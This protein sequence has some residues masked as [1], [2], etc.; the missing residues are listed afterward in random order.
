MEQC[1]AIHAKILL[2][3]LVGMAYT[4][5]RQQINGLLREFSMGPSLTHQ[6][7]LGKHVS[8]HVHL[9]LASYSYLDREPYIIGGF[10]LHIV[11]S[12]NI[13]YV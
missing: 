11:I 4:T 1:M 10:T 5:L 9:L 7:Q 8:E 12:I 2:N 3:M 13:E 6:F